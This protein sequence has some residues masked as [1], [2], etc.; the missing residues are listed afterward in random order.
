MNKKPKSIIAFFLTAIVTLIVVLALCMAVELDLLFRCE[1]NITKRE[2]NLANLVKF[3]TIEQLEKRQK[4]EP[5]NYVV[6]LKLAKLYEDLGEYS[7]A[8]SLYQDAVTKS[9]RSNYTLYSYAMFCAKRGLHAVAASLTDEISNSSNKNIK[10]KAEIYLTMA[11]GMLKNSEYLASVS[12]YQI[13]YKY[14]KNVKN[15]KFLNEV[16]NKYAFAYTKLADYYI[17]KNMVKEAVVALENSLKIKETQVANYKLGLIYIESNKVL[18]QKYME[19][20]FDNEPYLVNPYIYSSLLEEL[21]KEAEKN[22]NSSNLNYYSV[23]QNRFKTKMANLYLYKNDI[24]ISNTN[25][26][27]KKDD[28]YLVFNLKNN[29]NSRIEQLGKNHSAPILHFQ[30]LLTR[31]LPH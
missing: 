28:Y 11:D 17:E 14:A 25:V 2:L 4:N 23:K 7:T 8:N 18:A 20:V 1:S 19:T 3:A 16:K 30:I 5:G 27:K 22:G 24:L 15:E 6:K 13:A 31:H 12:A 26:V 10:F 9:N 29:T 21:I